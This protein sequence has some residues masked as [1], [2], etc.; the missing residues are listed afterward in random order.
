MSDDRVSFTRRE[1][2][3]YG[4]CLVIGVRIGDALLRWGFGW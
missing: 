1:L 2:F 3:W 4:V